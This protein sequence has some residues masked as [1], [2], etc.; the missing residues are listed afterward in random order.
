[1]TARI[2]RMS[3]VC[4]LAWSIAALLTFLFLPGLQALA[5]SPCP[6]LRKS[7]RKAYKDWVAAQKR[8]E[9]LSD[10]ESFIEASEAYLDA[11]RICADTLLE[12]N[13][14]R[15]YQKMG[16]C[17]R[18]LQWF[19]KVLERQ[20]ASDSGPDEEER[21]I[22]ALAGTYRVELERECSS[23]S[24]LEIKCAQEE[25]WLD[26]GDTIHKE[27]PFEGQVNAGRYVV[28]ASLE[29]FEDRK[30]RI[31][32]VAGEQNRV[33]IPELSQVAGTLHIECPAGVSQVML[34]GP[35]VGEL[36]D[37]PSSHRL[38][39][40]RYE[41]ALPGT[42]RSQVARV[43]GGE[44]LRLKMELIQEKV[45]RLGVFIGLR[46]APGTG[47]VAGDLYDKNNEEIP[48]GPRLDG[49]EPGMLTL[50][51]I[52][53]LG[54]VL[55]SDWSLMAQTRYDV[56][57][58]SLLVSAMARWEILGAESYSLRF[59]T[60]LGGGELLCPVQLS[61]A[62]EIYLARSGPVVLT[63]S[64]G[65][66]WKLGPTFALAVHLETRVGFPDVGILV[67]AGSV[68]AEVGF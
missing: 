55:S 24:M 37:C 36:V 10:K 15:M 65:L 26:I 60:G 11:Y 16:D 32:I 28:V 25:V 56:I 38:P 5:A 50:A 27:C 7:D 9:E 59:D 19:G 1:M 45:E 39:P 48:G 62:D 63:G 35:G 13:I 64:L 44:T 46:A 68:G 30:V 12:Y 8:A 54:Y 14:G 18:S 61:G 51:L 22:V 53:E 42:E 47:L 20:E 23:T 40:D 33:V 2:E 34:T 6:E 43:R 66:A 17:E 31:D 4:R 58:P 52:N 3:I 21:K 67:D 29:G 41:V 57:N 49:L